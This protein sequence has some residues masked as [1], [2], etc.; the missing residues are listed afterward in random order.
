MSFLEPLG[1]SR[2]KTLAHALSSTLF[3][4]IKNVLS[5]Y[6]FLRKLSTFWRKRCV[7]YIIFAQMPHKGHRN[8]YSIRNF[9][10]QKIRHIQ[11]QATKRM[12]SSF[13]S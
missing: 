1:I 10:L 8:Y 11:F 2:I 13:T 5:K 4:H 9:C 6:I 12:R 7:N 3:V